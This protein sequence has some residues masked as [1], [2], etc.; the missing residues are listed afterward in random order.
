MQN[1]QLPHRGRLVP[2]EG[3]RRCYEEVSDPSVGSCLLI[4]AS[5]PLCVPPVLLVCF[6][7]FGGGKGRE[8]ER[9]G[10]GSQN[11][12]ERTPNSFQTPPSHSPAKEVWLSTLKLATKRFPFH[13]C[14]QKSEWHSQ[15]GASSWATSAWTLFRRETQKHPRPR[16]APAGCALCQDPHDPALQPVGAGGPGQARAGLPARKWRGLD[17]PAWS[18]PAF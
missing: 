4:C 13:I 12:A 11:R 10:E 17:A 3:R 6:C 1:S 14:W 8:A 9:R 15:Q 7:V 5:R 18:A 16:Q 2:E